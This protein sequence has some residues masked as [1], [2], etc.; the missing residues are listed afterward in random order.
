MKH[1]LIFFVLMLASNLQAQ[2]SN[3][4]TVNNPVCTATGGQN[5]QRIIYDGMG[6]TIITWVDNRSSG[7][8]I[9]AQRIDSSGIVKWTNNGVLI[10]SAANFQYT[11]YLVSD[12]SGGAIITWRDDRGSGDIYAQRVSV[13]GQVKWMVDGVPICT[14]TNIQF[15]PQIIRDGNGGAIITWYDARASSVNSDIYAQRISSNGS[16]QWTPNG[17]IIC[18]APNNQGGP[19]LTTDGNGGAI[20]TWT[21]ERA[22][23]FEYDIYV[24]KVNSS[25]STQWTP[26]GVAVCTLTGIQGP[27]DIISDDNGGAIITW[28][29]TRSGE[30]DIYS[31]RINSNGIVQ[32]TPD[33]VAVCT[34]A[35]WQT[36]PRII[37]SASG[38][39]VIVWEDLR[40]GF[41]IYTQKVSPNGS[42]LW[43][44]DGIAITE[45]SQS[46][47]FHPEI[48]EDGHGG[49]IITWADNRNG[50]S[51]YDIFAQAIDSSGVIRWDFNGNPICSALDNQDYP[52]LKS[53]LH[54]GAFIA[55]YDR[56]NGIDSDIYA[57]RVS[58]DGLIPVELTSFYANVSEDKVNLNWSTATETNNSGF[59]IERSNGSEFQVI[60]F[61]AGHGTTTEIQNY[62]FTDENIGAEKYSYRLKQIDFNGTFV[63]SNEIKVEILLPNEFVLHQ[64]YPNPFN[65]STKITYSIPNKSFVTLKIFNSLGEEIYQLVNEEKEAGIYEINFNADN[66][67]TGVYLYK[68]QAGSFV[69]TKKMLLLK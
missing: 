25:G 13:N 46:F 39:A 18:S 40:N 65:P 32:W 58:Y 68:I 45:L 60:G 57:S 26:N 43:N 54:N 9:Y 7:G 47:Q 8:D 59:N 37:K 56:R 63:Y 11:P 20:I 6:G 34:A 38:S 14:A 64:N 53:D 30:Y 61:V 49:A 69:E 3:D 51:N 22:S 16:I 66:L 55:W 21:D 42:M 10:C 33:G 29:D 62:T 2:W 36:T 50:G 5:S 27:N 41:D 35:G 19:I 52:V 24:Q 12:D 4:P 23:S 67:P 44:P 48:T 15:S 31:Q 1:F 17:N 28:M